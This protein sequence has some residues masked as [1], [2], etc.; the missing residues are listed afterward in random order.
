MDLGRLKK[1][2]AGL[3]IAGL[4]AGAGIAFSGC[5]TTKSSGSSCGK[6]VKSGSS[7]GKSSCSGGEKEKKDKVEDKAKSSCSGG[8]KDKKGGSSCGKSSCN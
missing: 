2:M 3:G 7:C 4:I 1:L 5:A 6:D 8:E